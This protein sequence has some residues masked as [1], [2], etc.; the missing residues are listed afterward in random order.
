[1]WSSNQLIINLKRKINQTNSEQKD[2][3]IGSES[4]AGKPSDRDT[5]DEDNP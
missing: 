5:S 3:E 2:Q 1:M 4:I